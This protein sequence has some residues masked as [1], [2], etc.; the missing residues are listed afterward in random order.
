MT[1]CQCSSIN[2]EYKAFLHTYT[3][4]EER[5]EIRKDHK[6]DIFS[7]AA[8]YHLE[9]WTCQAPTKDHRAAACTDQSFGWIRSILAGRWECTD[10]KLQKRHCRQCWIRDWQQYWRIGWKGNFTHTN[11]QTY[12]TSFSEFAALSRTQSFTPLKAKASCP[13]FSTAFG[14]WQQLFYMTLTIQNTNSDV[15]KQIHLR[16]TVNAAMEERITAFASQTNPC[17]PTAASGFSH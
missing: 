2:L 13:F 5:K 1:K 11:L 17:I 14:L 7:S 12:Y 9:I 16:P 4:K 3:W 10:C 8:Q 6:V 15:S